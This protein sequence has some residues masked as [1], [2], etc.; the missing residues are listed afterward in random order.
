MMKYVVCGSSVE[1]VQNGVEAMKLAMASGARC[2][3]GG[4]SMAEVEK[5]LSEM[6]EMLLPSA[7]GERMMDCLHPSCDCPCP[8]CECEDE[9]E[10]DY[11]DGYLVYHHQNGRT[12]SYD[13]H[14]TVEEAMAY[15]LSEGYRLDEIEISRVRAYDDG[16]VEN[17]EDVYPN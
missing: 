10:I 7:L 8:Y 13:L 16:E 12:I 5:A 2:G 1:D 6:R 17:L 9:D 14:D 4:N 15:A 3:V 11:E